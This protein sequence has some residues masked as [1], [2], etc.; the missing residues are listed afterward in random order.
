MTSRAVVI[1]PSYVGSMLRYR[2]LQ[3]TLHSIATSE[4][5]VPHL[6]VLLSLQCCVRDHGDDDALSLA[7]D[8]QVERDGRLRASDERFVADPLSD[9]AF[10]D[11]TPLSSAVSLLRLDAI[12]RDSVVTLRRF[13]HASVDEGSVLY[14]ASRPWS[15]FEHIRFLA[16]FV[17]EHDVVF[18]SDD[19]DVSRPR[20]YSCVCSLFDD[21]RDLQLVQHHLYRFRSH[22]L[23]HSMAHLLLAAVHGASTPSPTEPHFPEYFQFVLRGSTFLSIL[24][25]CATNE[26]FDMYDVCFCDRL[27]TMLKERQLTDNLVGSHAIQ[28]NICNEALLVFRK[29]AHKRYWRAS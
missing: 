22:L 23:Y 21:N 6:T 14:G 29:A 26:Q 28:S 24:N 8:A 7:A 5:S 27:V 10:L 18:F 3:D 11:A 20:R 15:Q 1:I 19:D 13:E 9:V 17:G 16:Q 2:L 4:Q 25:D 12:F